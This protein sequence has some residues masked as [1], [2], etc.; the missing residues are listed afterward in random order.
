LKRIHFINV[1]L[2]MISALLAIGLI[3]KLEEFTFPVRILPL[4]VFFVLTDLVPI[5]AKQLR[6]LTMIKK[7]EATDHKIQKKTFRT[8][9]YFIMYASGVYFT[10]WNGNPYLSLLSFT[11]IAK[12]SGFITGDILNQYVNS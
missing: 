6:L 4:L 8:L 2:I 10:S 3:S 11:L 5:R 9:H 12:L 7:T 1:I